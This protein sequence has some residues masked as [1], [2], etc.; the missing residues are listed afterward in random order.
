MWERSAS[1]PNLMALSCPRFP[2]LSRPFTSRLMP[3]R[4]QPG[5]VGNSEALLKRQKQSR[6]FCNYWCETEPLRSE[7][8]KVGL[9]V[10]LG[11]SSLHCGQRTLVPSTCSSFSRR[12]LVSA[13]WAW[14]GQVKAL[15]G[16][17]I[18]AHAN[19]LAGGPVNRFIAR[20][21]DTATDI[22][23]VSITARANR[24]VKAFRV[25]SLR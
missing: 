25:G 9:C 13:S 24:L 4:H 14:R 3:R 23:R 6:S 17:S 1:F 8:M 7:T 15:R 19:R 5:T 11:N 18:A 16:N 2:Q 21:T 10:M 22:S 12:N 20:R